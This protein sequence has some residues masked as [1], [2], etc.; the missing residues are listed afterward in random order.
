MKIR[1]L[2]DKLKNYGKMIQHTMFLIC[3]IGFA[4]ISFP[5][6]GIA[7]KKPPESEKISLS[8]ALH[9]ISME[10]Q[11][12]FSYD[13]EAVQN[14]EVNYEPDRYE[15]VEHALKELLT[16]TS[17]RFKIF[18]NRYIILYEQSQ[19][20]I[21]SLKGMVRH[22]ESVIDDQEEISQARKN[23]RPI[24]ILKRNSLKHLQPLAFTVSGTVVDQNGETLIGVNIQ[25][26]GSNK[27]TAT[28]IDGRFTLED[29][30]EN[31][32]LV[33]SYIGFQTQE[34]AVAGKSSLNITMISDSQLLDEVV[35]VGYGTQKKVN[36]TGAIESVGAEELVNRPIGNVSHALQ[37]LSPG[38]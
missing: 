29:I 32:V 24:E 1:L 20:A 18:D 37:G 9:R 16:G 3:L 25:V 10:Y 38:L 7:E 33:I 13:Q 34:V 6:D 5:Q 36:L 35:V 23:G 31:A 8:E 12:F 11:V 4:M 2:R 14:I 30:D 19:Q 28:D 17:L 15:N 21:S 27:G 22:L 26:K